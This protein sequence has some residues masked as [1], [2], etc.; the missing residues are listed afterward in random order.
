MFEPFDIRT[1]LQ[2]AAFVYF[3]LAVVMLYYSI[4]CKTYPGFHLWTTG[5]I[6]V[7]IGL[8]LVSMRHLLPQF[9]SIVLGN[10]LIIILPI[11]LV[12]GLSKFLNL[13]CLLRKINFYILITFIIFFLIGT[14]IYPNFSFRVICIR[15]VLIILFS[16]ALY[17]S[18]KNVPE[19][20]GKQNWL[21]LLSFAV[22]ILAG[23]T[24]IVA[25]ILDNSPTAFLQSHDFI[26]SLSLL[27]TLLGAVGCVCSLLILNALRIEFDLKA[28][29]EKL[30]KLAVSDGIT[31]LYNRRY[32]DERLLQEFKRSQRNTQP[33]SLI[34]TDIDYFKQFND[35]YGHQAG[36][37]CIRKVAAVVKEAGA[38]VSDVAARYGGE[39]FVLLLPD[40]DKDGARKIANGIQAT[41]KKKAIAHASSLTAN[42][43]TLSIGVATIHPDQ[44]MQPDILVGFADQALYKSKTNGRNQIQVYT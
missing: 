21:L 29:T 3:T 16:E 36:D 13:K 14:Y 42:I 34:I 32:F 37:E 12:E 20:L 19:V 39:E 9:I 44:S 26:Q 41:L 22:L 5:I 25:T 28:A 38:R 8:A 35:T 15:I 40:V 1:M 17:I 23:I 31:G 4:V 11:L 7:S 18:F 33:L 43:V 24:R 30:E 27:S 10:I 2:V 6:S